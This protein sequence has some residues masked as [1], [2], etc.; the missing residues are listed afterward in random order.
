MNKK[1]R[2][3]LVLAILNA[4]F[5]GIGTVLLVALMIFALASIPALQASPD[6][7]STA[8]LVVNVVLGALG[9][10]F[11]LTAWIL[12]LIGSVIILTTDFGNPTIN[13][14]SVRLLWGLLSL[15]VLGFIGQ[16]IFVAKV[17]NAY[18][19]TTVA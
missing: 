5:M 9:G 7:Y 17:R 18:K 19:T 10:S 15:L 2:N 14:D 6:T 13:D 1:I 3:I 8:Y 12:N 4:V 11:M 16:F